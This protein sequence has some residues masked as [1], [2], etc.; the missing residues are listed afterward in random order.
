MEQCEGQQATELQHAQHAHTLQ[1][2]TEECFADL[3]DAYLPEDQHRED[4]A[5]KQAETVHLPSE[6]D[7]CKALTTCGGMTLRLLCRHFHL[8]QQKNRTG[9]GH[10]VLDALHDILEQAKDRFVHC[11]G[12][13][14]PRQRLTMQNVLNCLRNH[15]GAVLS[16][17]E[18]GCIFALSSDSEKQRLTAI[19]A[20]LCAS[21]QVF[22]E[23][24]GDTR[25]FFAHAPHIRTI[26]DFPGQNESCISSHP[27]TPPL[28]PAPKTGCVERK[29]MSRVVKLDANPDG[30]EY[31][32]LPRSMKH[33]F[34]PGDRVAC[35]T[36]RCR[37][38]NSAKKILV[39]KCLL[40]ERSQRVLSYR[41]C[42]LVKDRDGQSYW[43]AS[44]KGSSKARVR[45]LN[46]PEC[47]E[48]FS[49]ISR[50]DVV[51]CRCV[52]QDEGTG[53]ITV[54]PV[55]VRSYTTI[56]TQEE[57]VKSC[58]NV[59]GKFPEDV[60]RLAATFPGEP[61]PA[62]FAGREDLRSACFV[63]IDGA[64]AR[65]FDDAICVSREETGYV[66]QVAIADVSHYVRHGS[67]LDK[68]ALE[69]GNSWYFPT[70][71]QPMLPFFLS[72]GLCSLMPHKERLAICATMHLD[73]RGRVLS[74]S[75]APAV[76]SSQARLT[77]DEARDL[78]AGS[79]EVCARF[80]A[81]TC[82]GHDVRAMLGTALELARLMKARRL[83]RGA[84]D[85]DFPEAKASFDEEGHLL[86][87][88]REQHHEMHSLIEEFMLCAN[89][90]VAAF[91]EKK[92]LPFLYR[93]H[94]E[95][96]P[97]R[98]LQLRN[99]LRNT[100]LA[101]LLDPRELPKLRVLVPRLSGMKNADIYGNLWHRALK[102][103]LHFDTDVLP[104]GNRLYN[105]ASHLNDMEYAAQKA[106]RE[107]RTRLT[108]LWLNK[109]HQ[110]FFTGR[111]LS[112]HYRGCLVYLDAAPATV[113]ANCEAAG[114]LSLTPGMRVEVKAH[115]QDL[116]IAT[117]FAMV[118]AVF[119][120]DKKKPVSAL[121]KRRHSWY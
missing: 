44:T 70:S 63:T 17:Q 68:Q 10:D 41:A 3:L 23:G 66:L 78:V 75:F 31:A 22:S 83:K 114:E 54:V 102:Y 64:D 99:D 39:S 112:T 90:A 1:P 51:Q 24:V 74:S 56:R 58:N 5:E 109:Q 85:F 48:V 37:Q 98:L 121:P 28:G 38:G 76:I 113:F 71:V 40:L 32:A 82:N 18:L 35:L 15:D 93:I 43:L 33:A 7:I 55:S 69:R 92:E 106:E 80:A 87:Y 34:L 6:E 57:A 115:C 101:A 108:C 52:K 84:L 81:D 117:P 14:Y 86:S 21:E 59:P 107:M 29:G 100:E 104:A 118:T 61:D 53:A 11:H 95:P 67:L 79:P 27:C 97:E 16:L 60:A 91:L 46:T 119:V 13:Y 120:R 42:K 25:T 77:Y 4:A 88:V 2:D 9:A 36:V 47:R 50:D 45:I 73:G 19:L 89:E 105:I 103:A 62:D 20:K 111:V 96:D 65:D 26:R 94:P 8:E 116:R 110:A 30:H 72:H 49:R 12:R